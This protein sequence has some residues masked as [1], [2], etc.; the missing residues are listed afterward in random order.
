MAHRH[1]PV[2]MGSSQSLEWDSWPL[3]VGM[4]LAL[5]PPATGGK[6]CL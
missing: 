4:G 6:M 1:L 5:R 3:F 2:Y